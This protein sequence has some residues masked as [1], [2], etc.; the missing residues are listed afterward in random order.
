MD[1]FDHSVLCNKCNKKMKKLVV[2]R[3]G[4]NIRTLECSKCGTRTYHPSDMEEYNKFNKLKNQHFRVKLRQVGNSY[5]VSIPRE[6]LNFFRE[7]EEEKSEFRK[8]EERMDKMV[9]LALER[10]DRLS[11]SFEDLD[12]GEGGNYDRVQESQDKGMHKIVREK[13]ETKPI[14]GGKGFVRRR[15]KVVKISKENKDE[16]Y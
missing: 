10:A 15:I 11:L 12:F 5:A 4:F 8:I 1:I 16:Q 14:K 9:T 2:E 6:I 3:S 13:L 7:V